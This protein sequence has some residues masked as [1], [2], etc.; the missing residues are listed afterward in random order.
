MVQRLQV[1]ELLLTVSKATH[2]QQAGQ[3]WCR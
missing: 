2:P 3:L 1:G